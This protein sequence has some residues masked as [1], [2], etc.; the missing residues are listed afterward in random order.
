MAD[1]D[2]LIRQ[3]QEIRSQLSLCAE[4]ETTIVVGQTKA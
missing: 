3:F 1:I 2:A 4:A